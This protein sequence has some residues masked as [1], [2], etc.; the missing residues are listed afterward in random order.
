MEQLQPRQLVAAAPV[1]SPAGYVAP[2]PAPQPATVI[3]LPAAP[4][5]KPAGPVTLGAELS[6]SCLERPAPGYP[7][8]SRRMEE[9]GMVCL[10]YTSRCV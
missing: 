1:L 8:L 9:A 7:L 4:A 10:L 5:P 2:P 6:V 3:E